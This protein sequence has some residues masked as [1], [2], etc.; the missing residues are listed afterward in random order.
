MRSCV[1]HVGERNRCDRQRSLSGSRSQGRPTG[2][3]RS[4][5]TPL[6]GD[7]PDLV[8]LT[9]I[10]EHWTD[11]GK[12]SI[13]AINDVCFARIVGYALS[14]QM[15]SRLAVRALDNDVTGPDHRGTIVHS[16]RGRSSVLE[17]SL[18]VSSITR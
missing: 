8:W 14:D 11:E 9:D 10:T 4:R 2:A 7:K 13:C 6:R 12:L 15:T 3:R 1:L 17:R 16:D 5:Q 18:P